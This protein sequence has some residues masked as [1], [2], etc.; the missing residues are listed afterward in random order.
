MIALSGCSVI[1]QGVTGLM[2]SDGSVR[3]LVQTCP[4][5]TAS[6]LRMTSLSGA[7]SLTNPVW[8]FD[9]SDDVTV[10]LGS[11][12]A[13]LDQVG[14]SKQGIQST[15][16]SGVGGYLVFSSSDI[17]S[18]ED[19]MVLASTQTK[20]ENVVVDQQGF[21]DLLATICS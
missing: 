21:E 7:P 12:Q 19:G 16:S 13:F 4:D 8:S 6:D 9:A 15:V 1:C 11:V 18:L 20:D 10:D 5:V 17:E 14:E 2:V 3:A